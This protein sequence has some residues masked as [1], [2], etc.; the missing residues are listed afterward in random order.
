[1]IT[2]WI[3]RFLLLL[4]SPIF[5]FGL[6]KRKPNKPSIGSRWIE[7]FGYVKPLKAKEQPIWIHTVSVGEAI[8]ATPF[9]K[10][11]H[12]QFPET[13][14]LITTTTT[15]GA[16]QAQ[17][18]ADI[19]EH[20]YMPLDFKSAVTRFLHVV[21][22]KMLLVMETEL[23]PVT[24]KTVA[25]HEVP[26]HIINA[27]LSERSMKG[28]QRFQSLFDYAISPS[29]TQVVCQYQEDADRFEKLGINKK[30]LCISGNLKFDIKV[31]SEDLIKGNQLRN[32][33]GNDRPVWIA[34]ST[35]KGE[36]EIILK[37]H[38]AL[39]ESFPS[40]MLILVPRHPERFNDVHQLINSF[41]LKSQRHSQN[42][43]I[44]LDTQVYLGDTMGEMMM[45]LQ[46]SDVCFMGGSLLGDKVGGHNVL[47]PAILG[48]PIITGPSYYNFTYAINLLNEHKFIDI[49]YNE[50]E[51]IRYCDFLF[52]HNSKE[53][54]NK[55]KSIVENQNGSISKTLCSISTH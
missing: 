45:Y 10:K 35:H 9:I 33:I 47:E 8:A 42:E 48:K 28:Y 11:L 43:V 44:S 34:A 50:D 38:K 53:K 51:I 19:A 54:Q 21:Q 14:I 3:Y 13:P 30:K 41:Q 12:Q 5:L 49:A 52:R 31:N 32:K 17:K 15:T 36:D 22:P 37:S 18:L 46:A 40:L 4:S 16:E 24:L 55:L 2:Y 29:L 7:H 1:M 6:Y 25:K 23:W 20:R 26:I 27:R 39:L